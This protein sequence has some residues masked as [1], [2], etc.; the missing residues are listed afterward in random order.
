[1]GGTALRQRPRGGA[2]LRVCRGATLG[3]SRVL[4]SRRLEACPGDCL[5]GPGQ[6]PFPG[7]SLGG[8][9]C[10]PILLSALAAICLLLL[11]L[12]HVMVLMRGLSWSDTISAYFETIFLS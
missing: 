12:G 4:C 11:L 2:G 7:N 3:A 6:G 9:L 1:M 10:Y 8:L 5:E